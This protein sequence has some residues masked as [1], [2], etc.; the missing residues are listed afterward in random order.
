MLLVDVARARSVEIHV[1][2]FEFEDDPGWLDV[3][4]QVTDGSD[5]WSWQQACLTTDE[6]ERLGAWLIEASDGQPADVEL[7]FTEQDLSV[8][9]VAATPE[10]VT[11]DWRVPPSDGLKN[12][13]SMVRVTS[14][15]DAFLEAVRDWRSA[16]AALLDR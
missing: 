8:R 16:L 12:R 9:F 15:R 2:G 5:C 6:A 13:S 11:L 4:G 7:L 14:T 10:A 1:V 3:A